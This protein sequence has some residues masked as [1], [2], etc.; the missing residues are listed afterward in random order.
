MEPHDA[1]AI[2]SPPPLPRDFDPETYLD[3]NEDVRAAGIDPVA[4]YLAHGRSEGRAYRK[5]TQTFE[6]TLAEFLTIAPDYQNAFDIFPTAWSSCFEDVQT[7]G[8]FRAYDDARLNWL[9]E[10]M[11][12]AGKSVLEL[13]PLEGGHT[14]MLERAGAT[15]LAVESNKGAFLRCLITKNHFNLGAKFI[16]GDFE[17][18]DFG[19]RR[20]DLVLASGILYHMKDPVRLLQT[21]GQVSPRLFIW[22]HY[23][24]PDLSR[25][26]PALTP[27]LIDRK[28]NHRD[29]AITSAAGLEIR[30]VKQNYGEALGWS[31]FCGGSDTFSH[32]MY[33]ADILKLLKRIGYTKIEISFD[34]PHHPNGPAFCLLCEK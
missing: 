11:T 9:F 4:H 20:F 10:Q 32:W 15:V 18:M 5:V 7:N 33:R 14:L 3:L 2:P 27:D 22:T 1:A 25:W 24:D 31:G 23:F 26:N 19:G 34:E 12:L 6:Q 28:W 13:G 29:P 17:K 8:T 21:L 30:L 16:L